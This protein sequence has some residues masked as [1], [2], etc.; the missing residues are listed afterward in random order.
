MTVTCIATPYGPAA[1]DELARRIKAAK[2][3]DPLAPVTVVVPHNSSMVVP[4]RRE[5]ARRGAVAAVSFVTP[6]RLAEQLGAA[7]LQAQERKPASTPVLAGLVRSVLRDDPGRFA[8]V[9]SHPATE[10]SLLQAY[11]TLSELSQRARQEIAAAGDPA[12]ADVV[13]VHDKVRRKL[14]EAGLFDDPDLIEAA[15]GS[16]APNGAVGSEH[17]DSL[18]GAVIVFLPQHLRPG[19]ARLLRA[20]G[21]RLDVIVIAGV[22]GIPEADKTVRRAVEEALG[23]DWPD[24][25]EAPAQKADRALSVS[26]ADDEVRHALRL[27]VKAA[28]DGVPLDRIAILYGSREPYA[29]LLAAAL[30]T[31]EIPW[32]GYSTD[33]DENSLL[34]RSLL[35]MLSLANHDFSRSEV[36]AWLGG[37]PVLG[38]DGRICPSA[39]WEKAARAAGVVAGH[40]QWQQRLALRIAECE[41]EAEAAELEDDDERARRAEHRRREA[42]DAKN[43]RAF[44]DRLVEAL[45]EGEGCDTWRSLADWCQGLIESCLGGESRRSRWPAHER[46]AADRVLKAVDEL[47]NLD[48]IDPWPSTAVFRR[49]LRAQLEAD[50]ARHGKHGVGI[51]TGPISNAVG[52]EFDQV[53]V[54]GMAEGSMPPKQRDDP[55]LSDRVRA[56]AGRELPLASDAAG[57][58]HHAL[59]AVMAAAEHVTFTFPR[60]DL[61]RNAERV[62]SRWL[63]DSCE[64]RGEGR[65]APEK[66]ATATGDWFSEVPSFIAGMRRSGFAAHSHEYDVRA[67]LDIVEREGTRAGS[68]VDRHLAG[69]P[70]PSL[71]GTP[72][73]DVIESRIEVSRGIELLQGRLSKRFT[74]FDGNLAAGNMR[75][76]RMPSPADPEQV[77]SASR[78]EAWAKCPHAYFVQH[79][80]KVSHIEDPEEQYRISALDKGSMLHEILEKWMLPMIAEDGFPSDDAAF[81]QAVKR[82][83]EIADDHFAQIEERGRAGR[84]LYWDRDR[85]MM[86]SDLEGFATADRATRAERGSV[87]IAL[88]WAFGLR[89]SNR[90]AAEIDLGNGRTLR[91][92]GRVDRVDT[93]ADGGL[94]VIDYKTGSAKN[95]KPIAKDGQL[96]PTLGG[97]FLQ[98]GLYALAATAG[99]R[100]ALGAGPIDGTT[101]GRAGGIAAGRDGGTP[102]GPAE[103]TAARS[104]RCDYW[105]VT[106]REKFDR[107]GYEFSDTVEAAVR[108]KVAGIVDGIA[109]GQFPQHPAKP[110]DKPWVDCHY[111]EPD[112]LGLAHQHADWRRMHDDP[113]I[114]AYR[115]LIGEGDA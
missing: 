2:S 81:D 92:S 31:A 36:C 17:A 32:V 3:G 103:G 108:S 96:D 9:Q 109:A 15:L 53:V 105:F 30:G 102:P 87:P 94:H 74:R 66:I 78:L 21:A 16:L 57:D 5:L 39:A 25:A 69:K 59:L 42:E 110:G 68:T 23:D 100:G 111:C 113:G 47:G 60:G 40:A 62:P 79:V 67:M 54:L 56:L 76:I 27:V 7:S 75:G 64:A 93:T 50:P 26:D 43:L 70:A 89:G 77:V 82:L 86:R 114:G 115:E 10:R 45:A 97:R 48:G 95:Y 29:R 20:V 90:P 33:S 83:L 46:A 38:A 72:A 91:L 61:R 18:L 106:R 41:A 58:L 99:L 14:L 51:H 28:G 11:R 73:G 49:A 85:R 65:P 19:H 80:L 71:K 22:T 63:L 8:A 24:G 52:F 37:A 44:V 88:E 107:V 35:A 112:G 55:L 1:H 34:S 101:A 12:A 84:Q 104:A 98:L 6:L 4:A 13:R